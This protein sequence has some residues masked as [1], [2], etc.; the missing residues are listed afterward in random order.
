MPAL[1]SSQWNS[2]SN[3]LASHCFECATGDT[4]VRKAS[5]GSSSAPPAKRR[6]LNQEEST[7]APTSTNTTTTT[8]TTF[9][10]DIPDGDQNWLLVRHWTETIGSSL[11]LLP[12]GH[13]FDLDSLPIQLSLDEGMLAVMLESDILSMRQDDSRDITWAEP[14]LSTRKGTLFE[15]L[16]DPNIAAS[17]AVVSKLRSFGPSQDIHLD[18][19]VFIHH[20][21]L[22]APLR[23][24]SALNSK[25]VD[26]VHFLFPPPTNNDQQLT[27][28]AIKDL[29]TYLKPAANK[30]PAESLQPKDLNPKLLP[31]QKRTVT[32]M[33]ERECGI[34]TEYGDVVYKAPTLEEKLPLTWE[35]ATTDAGLELYINR[36]FGA[37]CLTDTNVVAAQVEPRGGILAEEMGLG[38]TVEMLALILLNRRKFEQVPINNKAI[39][40]VQEVS[41]GSPSDSTY[42]NS[43]SSVSC[44]SRGSSQEPL[45]DTKDMDVDQAHEVKRIQSGATLIITPPSI[46]Y[47]WAGEIENHAPTLTAYIY[48][49]D[50]H[51]SITA[52]V[53]AQYDIVLST[54]N[55][56]SREIN[57]VQEYDRSR[58]YER[59]YTPRKSPFML[60]D[61][62]RLCLDEAQMIEG[63]SVSQAAAV[64]NMIPR[65]M[66]WAVSGTP[67]RRHVEDLHSLLMFLDLQPLAS[68]K[69]LWR[70]LITPPFRS[71]LLSTF[72]R[73]MHRY[74]K[75]D[76]RQELALPRQYRLVYGIHFSEV[77]RA[78][79]DEKWGQCLTECDLDDLDSE[80]VNTESLQSWLTRLRQTCCH[81][82]IGK[83][84]RVTLGKSNLRTIDQ[85]LDV[86]I[87]QVAQQMY[88]KERSFMVS[89]I[90]RA[91]LTTRLEKREQ[92][93]Q[94]FL[95][96]EK[97]VAQKVEVFK[98]KADEVRLKRSQERDNGDGATTSKGKEKKLNTHARLEL[99][100]DDDDDMIV[101]LNKRTNN[102]SAASDKAP[103]DALGAAVLRH[104]DWM[105]QQ[106][107]VLFFTAGLY[108]DLKKE[109]EETE[110]YK[111]AE[112]V[113]QFMLALPEKKFDRVLEYVK[114]LIEDTDLDSGFTIAAPLFGGGIVLSRIIDQLV[115]VTELLNRQLDILSAW[116][117]DLVSRLIQPLMQDGEEGEQYQYSIDLQHTLESYLLFYGKMLLFRKDLVSGTEESIA[118]HVAQAE[119]RLKHQKMVQQRV[120]S[121]KRKASA[122]DTPAAEETI[123]TRLE[124]EMDELLTPDLVSTLR[125]IRTSIKSFAYNS[126]APDA[127]IAMADLED[128]R[129]K[130]EQNRQGKLLLDLE[131]E[132]TY[133]RTLTAARTAYYKQL[134]F[135]SDSVRDIESADPEEDIGDCLQEEHAIQLEIVRLEARQ[136]YLEHIAENTASQVPSAEEKLCLICRCPYDFGLMT[137]CGHVFCEHCLLEWTKNHHKCPSCNS[138]ISRRQLRRVAMSS[139]ALAN[140]TPSEERPVETAATSSNSAPEK[141]LVKA[142][143]HISH[144]PEIIRRM[145]IQDGFGSKIDSIVRHIAYLVREDSSIKCLVFSQWATLLNL[146]GDSL[147]NNQIGFVRLDG[148][149]AR[150]AVKEFKGNVNKHVFMLHAKSQSAGL[151]LLSATHVFI[152][153]PLVNPVLQA[154]AV[155]RVHRIGQTKETFVHYYV[156]ND[157]VE[158]PVF[159]LF[160]RNIAASSG[161]SSHDHDYESGAEQ[162]LKEL[163]IE[164]ESSKS[165][166]SGTSGYVD[167][168]M[169]APST[170]SEVARA[171]NR[172][173]ELVTLDDL[174]FCFRAQREIFQGLSADNTN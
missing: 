135:I 3:V 94:A 15:A 69:R 20:K 68:N 120:R 106:H 30:E 61:W 171:Q 81:P 64:A 18:I 92:E 48:S 123:D 103:E 150:T 85:V 100:K 5:I 144:V 151:T 166:G 7:G 89:R 31:F 164:G 70:T 87:E 136:R 12:C 78:N 133:F 39:N 122:A 140:N 56:L 155:S 90:K 38:K 172:N 173:G 88:S 91:V 50:S 86:M 165:S 14:G 119:S 174:K 46:L 73:I 160:E 52:E 128:K 6:M 102:G 77:E 161:A 4:R 67:M 116:R 17:I 95:S 121:F 131:R 2:F 134:Q 34:V 162:M 97:Q 80:E 138:L 79:Y 82:T 154:Q 41:V 45:L 13:N 153:E 66:S 28:N 110:Y 167:D 157:S 74:A 42:D 132:V 147:N 170:S 142:S 99:I 76:V 65:V 111:K 158:I 40:N 49:A 21:L 60:I 129:L 107:R 22:S 29:Y 75:K 118:Q 84:G 10:R 43:D 9:N 47:Q 141:S 126:T 159:N 44:F 19:S 35:T 139:S 26:L 51:K 54:Y 169:E 163:H 27:D 59:V 37:I 98:I 125:S 55:V 146:I 25:L 149:S 152:C 105:E 156:V 63:A 117:K 109:E 93:I 33:L 1:T 127:E 36:L 62:W 108:H 168:E 101:L 104:R 148:S 83:W 11:T 113:R 8:S 96:L 16:A 112:D 23:A 57:Y 145:P 32:W 53:L 71:L 137:E 72:Q 58:R 130:E 114:G 24:K 115:F 143:S 124:K